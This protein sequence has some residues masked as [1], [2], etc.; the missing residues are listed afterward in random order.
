[1]AVGVA[2]VTVAVVVMT[3]VVAMAVATPMLHHG[4]H[5]SIGVTLEAAGTLH[6]PGPLVLAFLGFILFRCN[7]IKR[8][9]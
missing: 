8:S 7:H 5:I 2:V 3:M 1:M 4:P 6:G 9:S